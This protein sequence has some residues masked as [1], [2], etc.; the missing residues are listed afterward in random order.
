MGS[1][2]KLKTS[3]KF[4]YKNIE[5]EVKFRHFNVVREDCC[6]TKYHPKFPNKLIMATFGN[7]KEAD[8]KEIP[9]N[10]RK[11]IQNSKVS[12]KLCKKMSIQTT[13]VLSVVTK[14]KDNENV[15]ENLIAG[16]SVCH[17]DD[18]FDKVIGRKKALKDMFRDEKYTK[19]FKRNFWKEHKRFYNTGD[20]WMLGIPKYSGNYKIRSNIGL[21]STFIA[22]VYDSGDFKIFRSFDI[23]LE[24]DYD[25]FENLETGIA[26]NMFWK[27]I[28]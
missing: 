13:A 15:F 10:F 4:K 1:T 21:P 20:G 8:L 27:K 25:M 12:E 19:E 7:W 5:Y 17:E 2:C 11:Q 14:N 16:Y 18:V 22:R 6:F 28:K 3:M 26:N 23:E 24:T 9:Y